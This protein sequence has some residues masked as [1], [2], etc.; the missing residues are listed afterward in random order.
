MLSRYLPV[1]TAWRATWT[2][3]SLFY[4]C[5]PV[6]VVVST[7]SWFSCVVAWR[8]LKLRINCTVEGNGGWS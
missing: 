7:A 6:P 2:I 4:A 5:R 8:R 3:F 1:Y